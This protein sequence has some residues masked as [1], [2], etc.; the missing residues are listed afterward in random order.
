M[1]VLHFNTL[2]NTANNKNIKILKK[3]LTNGRS[4]DIIIVTRTYVPKNCA[5]KT[6]GR[7]CIYEKN[8]I[9]C[10]GITL[11]EWAIGHSE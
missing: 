9:C 5:I 2:I 4:G 10:L 3:P 11:L 6:I 7:R 8:K 1:Y